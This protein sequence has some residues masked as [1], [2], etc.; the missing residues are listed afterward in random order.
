LRLPI[1]KPLPIRQKVKVTIVSQDPAVRRAELQQ[2][3]VR[4]INREGIRSLTVTGVS[5]EAGVEET[6]FID[7]FSSVEELIATVPMTLVDVHVHSVSA[8]FA[9]R[10]SLTES[11]QLAFGSYWD[12]V[13]LHFEM[14]LAVRQLM[15]TSGLSSP[16]RAKAQYMQ[17]VATTEKLLRELESVH[18]I[19]W[20]LPVAQL[21]RM[22]ISMLDGMLTDYVVTRD[23]VGARRTLDVF[24]YHLA[25][26]G[27]RAA[28]NHPK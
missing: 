28:K 25:Q 6:E 12:N 16:E 19:S 10:R 24:A 26:H 14:Q 7:V 5:A 22:S 17:V 23:S 11:L 18:Q 8:T 27:R 20:E 9:R 4:L 3:A 15:L 21:A 1:T 13:E 2:A